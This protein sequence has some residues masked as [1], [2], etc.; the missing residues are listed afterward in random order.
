MQ[1]LV[2]K[3]FSVKARI[4]SLR[5]GL[6]GMKIIF[7]NEHNFRIHCLIA[8]LVIISGIATGLEETEWLAIIIVSGLVF[9][10]EMFNSSLEYL[11]DYVSPGYSDLIKKVKDVAAA[12][13]LLSAI[14]SVITGI[15]IFYPKIF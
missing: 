7:S 6:N 4:K 15:C 2:N 10:S 5:Y 8:V 1:T 14:I 11:S 9:I 13:V 12:A 3:R